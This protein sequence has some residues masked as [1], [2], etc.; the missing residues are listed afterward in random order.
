[1][2]WYLATS[3]KCYALSYFVYSLTFWVVCEKKSKQ[4]AFYGEIHEKS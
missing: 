4:F 3:P 2:T 1:M